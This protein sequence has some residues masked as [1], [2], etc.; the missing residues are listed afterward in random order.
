MA[1]STF[2]I[3]FA[4]SSLIHI[5]MSTGAKATGVALGDGRVLQ[6][7][8]EGVTVRVFYDTFAVW[9]A[10]YE[11]A[12]MASMDVTAPPPKKPVKT[13]GPDLELMKKIYRHLNIVNLNNM[14]RYLGTAIVHDEL[15]RQMEEIPEAERGGAKYKE[16][17][18][19]ITDLVTGYCYR[20][21]D[22][23][24]TYQLHKFSADV[25]VKDGDALKPIRYGRLV[26]PESLYYCRWFKHMPNL[27][28]EDGVKLINY[29]GKTGT[30]FAECGVPL[31]AD[32]KPVLWIKCR[33]GAIVPW[34]DA[35]PPAY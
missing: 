23:R 17:S 22:R 11:A 15:R 18:Q 5:T 1:T 27:Y 8:R 2:S 31:D 16:L 33:S 20:A 32:G 13:M 24:V 9:L 12:T 7:K 34:N 35:S 10:S 29:E 30:T 3:P 26:N 19:C 6:V 28:M 25:F 21:D 4:K 14:S